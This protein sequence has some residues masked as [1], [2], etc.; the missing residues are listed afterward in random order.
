MG[1][2]E[3]VLGRAAS[4]KTAYVMEQ[5]LAL[6]QRGERVLLVVPEQITL[7]MEQRLT[8]RLGVLWNV[9]VLSPSRL[10]RRVLGETGVQQRTALGEEGLA[11]ALR[12]AMEKLM[13]TLTYYHKCSAGF[14]KEM[15]AVYTELRQS[16]ITPTALRLAADGVTEE[17]TRGKL[18]DIAALMD[19][20]ADLMRGSY[21]DAADRVDAFIACAPQSE[22]LKKANVFVDG[23]DVL[24]FKEQKL[25]LA[26]C[27]ACPKV[28]VTFKLCEVT[29]PDEALF[30]PVRKA[31]EGLQG[32]VL[33]NGLPY[34]IQHVQGEHAAPLTP[35][36]AHLEK[37]LY[38]LPAAEFTAPVQNI[39][40][41][42]LHD[43]HLEA[44]RAA[45]LL[46]S[47]IAENGWHFRET[48]VVCR[49]LGE[50]GE[51]LEYAF[52]RRG[53]RA[54]IDRALPCAF[55]P[56]ARYVLFTL[57]ALSRGLQKQDMIRCL[58]TG[59]SPLNSYE[60]DMME[61]AILEENLRG[62]KRWREP[63]D[64][65]VA[66]KA[67]TRF[68]KPVLSLFDKGMTK[69][70]TVRDFA[71][72]TYAFMEESGL[73]SRLN[74]AI[75]HGMLHGGEL[76]AHRCG[77]VWDALVHTLDQAVELCGEQEIPLKEFCGMLR[78]GLESV[79]LL[80]LPAEEDCVA[81]CEMMRFKPKPGLK[82]L[83]VLGVN[84][85]VL[86]AR[87]AES[88][89]L[90]QDEREK[91]RALPQG[92]A[93]T[94]PGLE[95]ES[96]L[97]RFIL[98]T[99]LTAPQSFLCLSYAMSSFKGEGLRPSSLVARMQR[100][101]P[102]MQVLG[103]LNPDQIVWHGSP[104][105]AAQRLETALT[106][107]KGG[108][109][110]AP[111]TPEL[112]AALQAYA[113]EQLQRVK[114]AVQRDVAPHTLP[115]PLAQKLYA[116]GEQ[117]SISRLESY[118]NCPF[119]HFMQYGLSP[120]I[121]HEEQ[122]GAADLGTLYHD[123]IESFIGTMST[124]KIDLAALDGKQC[125]ALMDAAALPSLEKM[126]RRSA[127]RGGQGEQRIRQMRLTLRRAGRTLV[128]QLKSSKFQPAAVESAFGKEENDAVQLTL[129]N[130]LTVYVRG[131]I[132]RVDVCEIDGKRYVRVIDYKSGKNTLDLADVYYGLR[133]QL[134][135]YLDAATKI[136][137]ALPAGV[138][139]FKIADMEINDPASAEQEDADE[140]NA[141]ALREQARHRVL[142]LKGLVRH[143]KSI[144]EAMGDPAQLDT[145]LPVKLKADGTLYK[146]CEGNALTEEEFALLTRYTRRKLTTLMNGVAKGDIAASP[147]MEQQSSACAYCDYKGV[148]QMDATMPGFAP[149]LIGMQ[150]AQA[151]EAM[152]RAMEQP[153]T[154]ANEAND[155]NDVNE[156][157]G[158]EHGN[159]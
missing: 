103:G 102:Q 114:S 9:E 25:L 63:L 75:R 87:P 41:A 124:G 122:V 43:A 120:R 27:M 159:G 8:G 94:L 158:D 145:I 2:V 109:T 3:Y 61:I 53:M 7:E 39:Q 150:K 83:V 121:I 78:A 76:D 116:H 60:Q 33:K 48:A 15:A 146:N 23:F 52:R 154:K 22:L 45:G 11:M 110:A 71:L 142:A 10:I 64:N 30:A 54:Y 113:P 89:L 49:S 88:G 55:H 26:L 34:T 31:F 126:S 112:K 66:A 140:T 108:V 21:T 105:L 141:Q 67:A 69:K 148:C 57:E 131:R 119:K 143:E 137:N 32:M 40:L 111:D 85:D 123:A 97:E 101:F 95:D 35:E 144:L 16:E 84:E 139:Y 152:R 155:T 74:K 125:D 13:P 20:M 156:K 70:N 38:A 29:D 133:L 90:R 68:I 129:E 135:V 130:G 86:P 147:V 100:L 79:Q 98:Y 104:E 92:I 17:I 42:A 58:K 96:A 81:V 157:G 1:A 28:T 118:A 50:Y 4:G 132:D 72:A 44:E 65:P 51:L 56:A 107:Q 99:T 19:A 153:D 24:P 36:L 93:V 136:E 82:A 151:L 117:T 47:L 12:S 80:G 149:R 62:E 59:F 46:H 6:Q 37:N 138:F 5:I 77:Q 18:Y 91:L 128:Y 14:L 134:F 73:R 115:I 106:V 127:M